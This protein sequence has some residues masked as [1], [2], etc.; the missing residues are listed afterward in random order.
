MR[1]LKARSLKA[2][3]TALEEALS[4]LTPGDAAAYFKH[5]GYGLD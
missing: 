5:S 4:I 2:L 3:Q 1:A